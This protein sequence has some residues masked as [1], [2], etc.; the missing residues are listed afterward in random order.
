L[1]HFYFK[2][3][4]KSQTNKGTVK[5]FGAR[6]R[7]RAASPAPRAPC[8][9]T[10]A[11]GPRLHLPEARAPSPDRSHTEARWNPSLPHVTPVARLGPPVRS[12]S[13]CVR[14]FRDEA[15]RRSV[16]VGPETRRPSPI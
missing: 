12:L 16:L 5:H 14:T 6:A 4:R 2:I 7:R 11:T 1:V 13:R 3:G 15:A 9:T 8:P 10:S